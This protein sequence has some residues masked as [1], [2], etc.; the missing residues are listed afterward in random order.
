[1]GERMSGSD[2]RTANCEKILSSATQIFAREGFGGT[3]V[4]KIAD[5]CGLPKANVLYYFG[6][7]MKLYQ[8]VLRRIIELWNSG[9]DKATADDDPKEVLSAYIREKM[10]ISRD[11]PEASKVFA[12]EVINGAPVLMPF[13]Q[14]DLSDWFKARIALIESWIE[15]GKMAKVNP[16]YLLFQIWASTQHYA[17]FSVQ[18]AGLRG[19]PLDDKSFQ[20]ATDYLINSIL[21]GCGLV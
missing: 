13:L 15:Q 6:S 4:Q 11:K 18:I 19:E 20:E 17:D 7:K 3:T 9:F 14:Q 12:L 16:E 8:Q 21:G 1:M 2:I 10:R 5:D